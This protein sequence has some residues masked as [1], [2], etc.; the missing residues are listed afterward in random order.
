M[1][2]ALAGLRDAAQDEEVG[3]NI[4]DID[5]L[6]LAVETFVVVV[7]F[8]IIIKSGPVLVRESPAPISIPIP[9]T[10]EVGAVIISIPLLSA[11][12]AK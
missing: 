11:M 5:R 4:N 7:D 8:E 1:L 9:R 10:P 3:Q 6:E 2:A 12:G